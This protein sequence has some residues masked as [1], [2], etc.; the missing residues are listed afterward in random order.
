MKRA[1]V[2][3]SGVLAVKVQSSE[4][5]LVLCSFRKKNLKR[6]VDRNRLKRVIAERYRACRQEYFAQVNLIFYL[7]QATTIEEACSQ[8]PLIFDKLIEMK[9]QVG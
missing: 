2:K 3:S 6:A 9:K 4:F 7:K 8:V 1:R 5:G